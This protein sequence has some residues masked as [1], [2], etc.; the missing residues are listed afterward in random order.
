MLYVYRTVYVDIDV[1]LYLS[2][3]YFNRDLYFS[4]LQEADT[5]FPLVLFV[6]SY[7]D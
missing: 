5:L 1:V 3:M 4:L 7:V 2:E 6:D